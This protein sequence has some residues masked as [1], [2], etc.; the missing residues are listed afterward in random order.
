MVR[1]NSQHHK[2]QPLRHDRDVNDIPRD[3]TVDTTVS[4]TPAPVELHNLHEEDIDH[5]AYGN[6]GITMVC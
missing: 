3:E 4:S 1:L 6:R 2:N 5:H